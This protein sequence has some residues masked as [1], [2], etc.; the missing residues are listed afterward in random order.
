[1]RNMILGVF[2]LGATLV[3]VAAEPAPGSAGAVVA[4]LDAALI[5]AMKNARTL[6]Y[7]GRYDALAPVVAATHDFESISKLAVGKHWKTLSD[8][9]KT[10]LVKKMTEYSIA[11][12]AAQFDAYNDE[13]FVYQ[14]EQPGKNERVTVRYVLKSSGEPNHQFDYNMAQVNGQ[15]RIINI[16]VDGISDLA[17]KKAQYEKIIEREGFDSLLGKL[18]EKIADYAKSRTGKSS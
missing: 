11:T 4:R 2:L 7:Q 15:W 17:L 16:V 18:A 9:Q 1:M 10:S 5:E 12:Y 6:G 13:E 14:S 8:E 3:S